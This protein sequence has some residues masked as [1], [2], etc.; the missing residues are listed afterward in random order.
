[1]AIAL[2]LLHQRGVVHCEL[3][4][5]NVVVEMDDEGRPRTVHATDS[6]ARPFGGK[7]QPWKTKYPMEWYCGCCY[8]G[9]ELGLKCDMPELGYTVGFLS[10][11]MDSI[12]KEHREILAMTS[13]SDHDLR[14][15]TEDSCSASSDSHDRMKRNGLLL[16]SNTLKLKN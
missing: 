7:R 3:K 12:L 4:P 11:A 2:Q 9:D 8:S 1:M 15:G 10:E 14:R 5:T 13:E 16:Q 6:L